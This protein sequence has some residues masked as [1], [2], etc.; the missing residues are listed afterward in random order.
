MSVPDHAQKNRIDPRR[1]SSTVLC[2][3]GVRENKRENLMDMTY[4]PLR[5][6][7]QYGQ[8]HGGRGDQ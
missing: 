8:P 4:C 6:R 5:R 7:P 3:L 1:A 2:P